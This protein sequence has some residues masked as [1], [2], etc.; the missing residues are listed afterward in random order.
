MKIV[1]VGAGTV[2]SAIC[3]QL[4][5][6]GHD[7]T[8]VDSNRK[9][10]ADI[11]ASYDVVGV[12]G[13]GADIS[14]L[15]RAGTE[16]ADL[17]VAVT[18]SDEINIL[19]CT[20][21]KKLGA[22]NTVARVRNPEYYELMSFMKDDMN[23]SLTINPEY[24]AAKEVY[25][26]LRFPSATKV[27]SFCHGR[28]ELAEFTVDEGSS[29]C[30]ISLNDLRAKLNIK[31]LV[32]AVLRGKEAYIPK[33]D[34]KLEAGDVICF[35]A[36]DAELTAFFKAVGVYKHPIRDVLIVGGG[37]V[38]YYLEALLKDSKI[39]SVVIEQDKELCRG[40]AE[41]YP[42]TVICEDGMRQNVLIEEGIDR[43]DAFV[44][45]SEGDEENAIIS[46]YAKTVSKCKV[47]TMIKSAAYV[48]LFKIA[49]LDSVVSPKS[50]TASYILRY[51]RQVQA[52]DGSEIETLHK[53]MEDKVEALEFSIK[54]EIANITDVELK[55][56]KLRRG[57]LVAC[58]IRG[59]EIIIPTGSDSIRVGDTV[60]ITALGG[61]IKSIKDI[62]K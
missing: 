38:T 61:I 29:I 45:L 36:P 32:C 28:V 60:I 47:I 4:A 2:G 52:A 19:C 35:T 16:S 55:S 11:S 62:L 54:S 17:L 40:L 3:A 46:M 13:N 58:I 10:L 23:L 18:P 12:D 24:A 49:G 6:E 51:V 59:E 30:G 43:T 21:A 48:D 20:A 39:R 50:S 42:C 41:Q 37:R 27:N 44:A 33:G 15:R 53:L 8:L 22:K 1:I 5:T 14:A 9:A 25:R 7:I 31:F 56:L 57:V 34:F 26:M